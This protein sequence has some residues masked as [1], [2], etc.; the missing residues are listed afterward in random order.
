VRQQPS[1]CTSDRRCLDR[2]C[3]AAV[4]DHD[5]G[6]LDLPNCGREPGFFFALPRLLSF[7]G[8]IPTWIGVLGGAVLDIADTTQHVKLEIFA[9]EIMST[10]R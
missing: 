1:K 7:T 4:G 5:C 8:G 2:D 10:G 3:R 9:V 6:R